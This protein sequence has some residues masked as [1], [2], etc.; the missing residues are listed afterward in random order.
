MNKLLLNPKARHHIKMMV[1]PGYTGE[2][3]EDEAG[4]IRMCEEIYES[5]RKSD[6]AECLCLHKAKDRSY[7]ISV[8]EDRG[9]CVLIQCVKNELGTYSDTFYVGISP[10]DAVAIAKF[11]KENADAIMSD[12]RDQILD[13]KKELYVEHLKSSLRK[14]EA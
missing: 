4:K 13:A 5:M 2:R 7:Q 3:P 10:A 9:L 12:Y 6:S 11:L 14:G 8:W 1:F